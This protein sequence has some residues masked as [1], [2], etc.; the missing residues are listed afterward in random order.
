MPRL[1]LEPILI[2]LAFFAPGVLS[3]QRQIF[4]QY[5][6]SD[7][8]TNLNVRC[9][10]QDR[11]G[12]LWV[13]TDNGLF[14]FDGTIFQAFGHAEGLANTEIRGLAE[15]P[16]GVLWVATQGGVARRTGSRFEPVNVGEKGRFEG[17]AFDS[18]GRIY[19]ENSSGILR[20]LPELS[21]SGRSD[22][23]RF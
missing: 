18:L 11:T 19:L 8:L 20:G 10:L 2:F 7:G 13:G 15:S 5:G 14:R 16:R 4:H 17:V 12:Y 9:L 6:S 3:A 21:S 1:R 22:S 23:Y